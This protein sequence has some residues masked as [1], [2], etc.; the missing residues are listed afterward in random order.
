[1]VVVVVGVV[2]VVVVVA[3]AGIPGVVVVVVVLIVVVVVVVVGVRCVVNIR[4]VVVSV[5]FLL[6]PLISTLTSIGSVYLIG[7]WLQG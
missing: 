6:S 7:A 2:V 3:A 5:Y 1:V 4:M